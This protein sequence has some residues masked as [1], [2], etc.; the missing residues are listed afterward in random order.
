MQIEK[1]KDVLGQVKDKFSIEDEGK[2]HLDDHGGVDI[3]YVVFKGPLGLMRLEYVT[4]PLVID[5]KT[6]YSNRIGSEAQVNYVY[7]D[8]EKSSKMNAYKWDDDQ[9]DWVEMESKMFD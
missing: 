1:W 6:N 3:E 5:K 4:K 8:D 9:D 7:S 2:E